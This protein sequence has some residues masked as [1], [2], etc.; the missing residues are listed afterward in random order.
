MIFLSLSILPHTTPSIKLTIDLQDKNRE[1]KGFEF[2]FFRRETFDCHV[3]PIVD[4]KTG[5]F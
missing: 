2:K 5:G 3:F 4:N 1:K